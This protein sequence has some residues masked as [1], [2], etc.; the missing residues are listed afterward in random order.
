M[1]SSAKKVSFRVSAR[2]ARLIGRENVATSHGAITELVKNS[3][4]ADARMCALI[5]RRKYPK[6]PRTLPKDEYEYLCQLNQEAA[7]YFEKK[8]NIYHLSEGISESSLALLDTVFDDFL[9]LWIIDNGSGMSSKIIEDRWMVIGTDAKDTQSKSTGGRTLTGAKGIGRFALDR[10]GEKSEL[11]SFNS[12]N[13]MMVHWSVDWNSFEGNEKTLDDVEAS[14]EEKLQAFP[15]LLSEVGLDTIL[16]DTVPEPNEKLQDLSYNTGTALRLELLRDNWNKQEIAKLYDSLEAL[17]PPSERN[18]FS[19][20]VYHH[21]DSESRGWLDSFPPDQFDYRLKAIV[22]ANGGVDIRLDRQ[23]IDVENIRPSFYE[24]E[25][26]NLSGYTKTDFRKGYYS[27]S[28]TLDE[29]MKHNEAKVISV[30]NAVGPFEVVLYYI[31]LSNPTKKNLERFPQKSFDA[32]KRRKWMKRSGGIRIY[33]DEFRVRPFGEPETQDFDWLR[34]G[35]RT[36]QNPAGVGSKTYWRVPPQQVA[37]TI[38]IT[39]NGNPQLADQSNREGIMNEHA[40]ASFRDIIVVLIGEFEKD[41]NRIYRNFNK[42]YKIDN[43]KEFELEKTEKYAKEILDTPDKINDKSDKLDPKVHLAMAKT[44]VSNKS[45]K[46]SMQDEMRVLRGMATLGTVLVSFTHELKQIKIN[47]DSHQT[48]MKKC[49]DKVIPTERLEEIPDHFNP[50]EM[51]EQWNSEDQK[52]SRWLELALSS[53]TSRKRRRKIIKWNDYFD[54]LR[55]FWTEILQEREIVFNIPVDLDPNLSVLAH[56][57]NLDSIF[58]NLVVNS[59]EVLTRPSKSRIRMIEIKLLST[60]D[61]EVIFEYSDNGPGIPKVFRTVSD[62]FNYGETSKPENSSQ[63]IEGTGIGMSI[64]KEIIDDYN[65]RIRILSPLGGPG[66]R[67]EIA[68]PKPR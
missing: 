56:E 46:K 26:V 51:L 37:G 30:A 40:F 5:F 6:I 22:K 50:Y 34:L 8:E 10:L 55:N 67:L 45:E 29:L 49:L 42:A 23:E 41:R 25:E 14:L 18:D 39:R 32:S 16:P 63:Q 11:Y 31:K 66:F 20:F 48:R 12:G 2:T 27:Y 58:F 64:V 59:T 15:G 44:I 38:H 24:L 57:I 13:R 9:E 3:Y 62:I 36:A 19:I 61:K 68:L 43:P 7:G 35:E 17:L 52:I 65:G 4:D 60:S 47:I 1:E 54:N 21:E 28:T 53:V 33:R